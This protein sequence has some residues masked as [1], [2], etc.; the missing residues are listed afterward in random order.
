MANST[1]LQQ[2]FLKKYGPW[3]LITGASSGIGRELAQ[4]LA[5]SK[6]N[7]VLSARNEVHLN[8]LATQ[9][10]KEFNIEVKCIPTDLSSEN[11][12]EQLKKQTQEINIGLLIAAAGYGTSGTFIKNELKD[13]INMLRLNNETVLSLT[14]HFGK[15]FTQQKRGGIILFSSIVAFQGSPYAAHYAAT[16]AYV[17]TLAEGIRV[18]LKPFGVDVL[19]VAPGPVNTGFAARAN[20]QMKVTLKPKDLVLPILKALGKQTT[21][22]PGWLSKL[23]GYSLMLTPRFFKIRIL[24]IVMKEMSIA[25]KV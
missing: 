7:L 10:R 25:K 18:E 9:L 17:Q 5:Q 14:R 22:F 12:I 24:G 19:A 13:E 1:P 6:F 16:K 11:G 20:M 21:V 4:E 23:F 15:I 8:E 3:A 2:K